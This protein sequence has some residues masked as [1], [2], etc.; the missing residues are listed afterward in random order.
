M[1]SMSERFRSHLTSGATTL[2][3]CW[4]LERRDGLVLGFTDHDQALSVADEVYS[5]SQG[6]EAQSLR[7]GES[8]SQGGVLGLI[9]SDD[10][11]AADI[12]A[13]LWDGAGVRI[14]RVNWQ[15]PADYIQTFVGELGEIQHGAMSFEAE[16]LGLTHRLNRR[17]G[18]VFARSCDANLGD[19]RCGVDLND[20]RYAGKACDKRFVTCR[21]VFANALNFRGMPHMP[22]NDVLLRSGDQEVRRDGSSRQ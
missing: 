7:T 20:P 10:I 14:L 2:A 5:P 9:N 16:V 15:N 22:G 8:P 1:I 18:R 13:G 11:T 12:E 17:I 21:Q 19:E 3:W 6:L 4:R